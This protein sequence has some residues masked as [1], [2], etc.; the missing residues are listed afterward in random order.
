MSTYLDLNP[1]LTATQKALKEETN[2]FAKEVL[3]PAS[4]TLDKLAD[5]EDVI[6]DGSVYWDVFRKHYELGRHL[7]LRKLWKDAQSAFDECVKQDASYT[8]RVPDLSLESRSRT[9]PGR[10]AAAEGAG[11]MSRAPGSP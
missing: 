9:R 3:R 8:P 5:P 7:V 4:I 1:E 6:R 10:T 11:T 2:R